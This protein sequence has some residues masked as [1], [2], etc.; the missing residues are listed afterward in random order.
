VADRATLEAKVAA[1]EERFHG[2]DVPR[3]EHWTGIRIVPE[4]VEFWQEGEH[5]LHDR[6]LYIRKGGNWRID[7]LNP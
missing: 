2:R 3:P 5:R 7:R 1:L 4:E 6:F